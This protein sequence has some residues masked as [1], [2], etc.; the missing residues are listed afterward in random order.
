LVRQSAQAAG[1]GVKQMRNAAELAAPGESV[2]REFLQR[3]GGWGF[4]AAIL[5]AG[6]YLATSIQIASHRLF[7][8][9]ELFTISIS[10]LPNLPVMLQALKAD[11]NMPFPYFI[12]V[13]LF[14]R[15]LGHSEMAARLPSALAMTAGLLIAFDCARRLTD[16]LHGL[17]AVAFLVCTFLPYFGYEARSYGIYFMFAALAFWIWSNTSDRKLSSVV[18]F[19]AVF[20]LGVSFHYYFVLCIVPYALWE[21][22]RWRPWRLPSVKLVA[23]AIGIG[24]AIALLS[25]QVMGANRYSAT[26]WS[27]PSL[28]ALREA[29]SAIFPDAAFLLALMMVLVAGVLASKEKVLPLAPMTPAE[30]A[31]WLC[32]V[33]PLAGFV[34]AKLVT[35]AFL[36]RYF[37]G[38]LPGVGIA[39]ACSI[40]R[41]FRE[42]GRGTPGYRGARWVPIG[43]FLLLASAG[44]YRQ[45]EVLRHP[46]SIDPF[47]QQTQT[48]AMMRLE[49][50]LRK[51]GKRFFLFSTGMLYFPAHFYSP[52]PESYVLLISSEKDLEATN[53]LRYV[54]ALR[55]FYHTEAWNL[56][57]LRQHAHETALI[58]P[59]A[60]DLA[61]L[62]NAGFQ[63][64]IPYAQPLRIAYLGF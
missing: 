55:R 34:L 8:F 12:V 2:L 59:S 61:M 64:R 22:A 45:M 53:T 62:A 48:R 28:F 26:F 33:I 16:G 50:D 17:I 54:Y 18:L 31:G 19:G 63:T 15:L 6:F 14:E 3:H 46:E 27:K 51:D 42:G 7:W 57:D 58:E 47:N 24:C 1:S 10:R 60:A 13:H 44:I 40:W 25:G 49:N 20:L 35:N 56:E 21:A 30:S 52:H 4:A 36:D 39:F 23:G 32:L 41:H 11:N 38:M 5:L 9:D 43:V 29:F 37:I